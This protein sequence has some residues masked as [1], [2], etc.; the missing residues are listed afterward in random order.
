MVEGV[1]GAAAVVLAD[2]VEVSSPSPGNSRGAWEL[3][4]EEALLLLVLPPAGGADPLTVEPP[5]VVVAEPFVVADDVAVEDDEMD[6]SDNVDTPRGSDPGSLLIVGTFDCVVVCACAIVEPR[7]MITTRIMRCIR[8]LLLR[9]NRRPR[10]SPAM[11]DN[12]RS[13]KNE[14]EV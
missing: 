1:F 12:A 11:Q 6:G 9:G 13:I 5:V 8:V 14:N 10:R 3:G 2:C 7:M 4:D